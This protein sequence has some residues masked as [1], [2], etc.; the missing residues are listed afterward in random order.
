MLEWVRPMCNTGT[1]CSKVLVVVGQTL[2]FPHTYCI[3]CSAGRM[4]LMRISITRNLLVLTLAQRS[5][6]SFHR[7]LPHKKQPVVLPAFRKSLTVS[8]MHARFPRL[9]VP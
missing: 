7:N 5:V 3:E 9:M 6:F 4:K 1:K 8:Q 2:Q